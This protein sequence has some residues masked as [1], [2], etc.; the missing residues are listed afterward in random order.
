MST[1]VKKQHYVWQRYLKP[2][3]RDGKIYCL[4][5]KDDKI[6]GTSTA[7]VASET[8]FYRVSRLTTE[9]TRYIELLIARNSFT[10]MR[11][12]HRST[13]QMFQLPFKLKDLMAD[14]NL[15]PQARA[16]LNFEME[17]SEK[18]IG[19]HWHASIENRAA[20]L[21][22]E[23]KQSRCDFFGDSAKALRFCHYIGHQLFRTP[24]LKALTA[25][26]DNPFPNLDLKR[27]W[28][29]ESNIYADNI[30][31]SIFVER[32]S[33]KFEFLHNY[34]MSNFITGDQPVVNIN[35]HTQVDL[36]LFYPLGPNLGIVL[37]KDDQKPQGQIRKIDADEANALNRVVQERSFDQ[38]YS[39]SK[40]Q[41]QEFRTG[42]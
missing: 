27:T 25:S 30:S 24:K 32:E 29:I 20:D 41:L 23:L 37:H 35:D 28:F 7:A 19:E 6:F 39:T 21:T 2:W 16:K 15:T 34:S 9:D 38:I 5:R 31:A 18:T 36:K 3:V 10:L 13:L 17:K 26:M 12:H 8:F 40:A 33:H 4:R 22:D 42:G 11:D 1:L 14:A